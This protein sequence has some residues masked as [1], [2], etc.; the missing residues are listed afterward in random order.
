LP[1]HIFLLTKKMFAI[2]LVCYQ[3]S[4]FKHFEYK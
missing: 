1:K 4:P 2:N 3:E